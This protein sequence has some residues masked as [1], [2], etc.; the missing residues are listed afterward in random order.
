MTQKDGMKDNAYSRYV[1]HNR[2][3]LGN[4]TEMAV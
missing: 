1:K 2:F 3:L 4:T